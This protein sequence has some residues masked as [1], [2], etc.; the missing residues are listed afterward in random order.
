VLTDRQGA[1]TQMRLASLGDPGPAQSHLLSFAGAHILLDAGLDLEAGAWLVPPGLLARTPGASPPIPPPLARAGATLVLAT[2]PAFK[3]ALYEA[4]PDMT[5][6]AAILATSPAGLMGLPYALAAAG[7]GAAPLILAPDWAVD[8]AVAWAADL[9]AASTS[10]AASSP[11]PSSTPGNPSWTDA[12][13]PPQAVRALPMATVSVLLGPSAASAL[14][15]EPPGTPPAAP[16]PPAV[17]AARAAWRAGP[18]PVAA[19]LAAFA[20]V[21]RVS[22]GEPVP[23]LPGGRLIATAR[24]SGAT[25]GGAAWVLEKAPAAGKGS[26]ERVVYLASS[27]PAL[28]P[29]TSTSDP[30]AAVDALTAAVG[31]AAAVAAP[32]EVEPLTRA[33]VLIFAPPAV[34][35]PPSSSRL[36][37]G[38]AT[39]AAAAAA[40]EAAGAG[41]YALLPIHPDGSAYALL[42][43]SAAALRARGLGHIPLVVAGPGAA[44]SLAAGTA[45]GEWFAPPRRALLFDGRPPIGAGDLRSRGQLIVCA[46]LAELTAGGG[47]GGG[48]GGGAGRMHSSSSTTPRWRAP[49]VVFAPAASLRGDGAA[50]GG[51][52][53]TAAALARAWA[54]EPGAALILTHPAAHAGSAEAAAAPFLSASARLRLVDASPAAAPDA[55]VAAALIAALA[56]RT[57]VIA[58]ALWE[59]ALAAAVAAGD[60]PAPG[61]G[62]PEARL[63]PYAPGVVVGAGESDEDKEEP[64]AWPADV[65]PSLLSSEH[66]CVVVAAVSARDGRLAVGPPPPP[67]AAAAE[68]AGAAGGGSSLM[69][70]ALG[71]AAVVLRPASTTALTVEGIL[72]ALR[73]RGV[74]CPPTVATEPA[75]VA[76]LAA[77]QLVARAALASLAASQ[78]AAQEVALAPLSLPTPPPP[79]TALIAL[80]GAGAAIVLA[81]GAT[82]VYAE[83]G[84]MRA[85]LVEAVQAELA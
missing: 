11:A 19:A 71:P 37:G 61:C 85:V 24:P 57:A 46:G 43:A 32:L 50:D 18:Y 81:P 4:H 9:G 45:G 7:K 79:I 72:T 40:A 17:A 65:E 39:L 64:G 59:D 83:S 73:A 51:P 82:H 3:A 80:P 52:G 38:P 47:G 16:L 1:Q 25:P 35:R 29:F 42:E 77:A 60:A 70:T 74:R 14:A 62:R 20:T 68:A 21:R 55:A 27:A 22:Y 75:A 13:L 5:S 23:L 2:P 44:R 15:G 31:G 84:V 30:A 58:P 54:G 33:D 36:A 56:P 53:A 76:A 63:T 6:L 12:E 10:A 34:P 41:A 28:P 69:R 8:V 78:P 26:V 49:A 66:R 48:G 67:A